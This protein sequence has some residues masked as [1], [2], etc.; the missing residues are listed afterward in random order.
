MSQRLRTAPASYPLRILAGDIGGTWARWALFCRRSPDDPW[1]MDSPLRLRSQEYPDFDRLL[2]AILPSCSLPAEPLMAAGFALA[3]PVHAHHAS[4]RGRLTNLSWPALDSAILQEKLGIPVLLLNDFAAVGWC[5]DA[6]EP[7]QRL[8]LQSGKEESSGLRLMVGAGT[9]LGS[10]LVSAAPDRRVY[11]GEGGHANFAPADPEQEHL[12]AWVR[13]REGRCSREHLVSGAG[14]ARIARFLV[15]EGW[16]T[17]VGELR[18][19]LE[20]KDPAAAIGALA[21]Q[22]HPE[23]LRVLLWFVRIYAGQIGDMALNA[24]PRGGIFIA[25]GIAQQWQH[26]FQSTE[27]LEAMSWKPPMQD[28]LKQLPVHLITHPDPGLLGAAVAALE[29]LTHT[30]DL[31]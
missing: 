16:L 18:L 3:G 9:G 10:C 17:D 22:G 4:W 6:L 8:C 23:S 21:R 1:Q 14:I 19:A 5:V 28:I 13:S 12:A 7:E 30:G 26:L 2:D 15:E 11:P 24:L 31:S 20:N 25:G 29:S 27:F